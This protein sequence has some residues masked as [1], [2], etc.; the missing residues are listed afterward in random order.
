MF[1]HVTIRACDRAESER[2]YE[3]VLRTIGVEQTHSDGHYAEWDDFSLAAAT[4]EQAV[5]RRLHI[6]FLAP[7]RAHVDEFWRVGVSAGYRDD[8]APSPR[9][10]Y[11]ERYYGAFLLDPD[12]NSAEAVLTTRPTAGSTT[13]GSASRTSPQQNASTRRSP[14]TADS[15][16][17]TTVQ[18]GRLS[19]PPMLR[20]LWS[21][22]NRPNTCTSRSPRG[23]TRP[24]TPSTARRW[25]AATATTASGPSTTRATTAPT[26]SIPTETTSRS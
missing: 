19:A 20:S 22:G 13:S 16:S 11:S 23:R 1:D 21:A 15:S 17:A 3:T 24:W 2:F 12:G 9:P 7:S 25:Q 26:S 14:R 10:L 4:D 8:G 18:S 6:G 5:T